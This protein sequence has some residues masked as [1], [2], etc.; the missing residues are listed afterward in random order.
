MKNIFLSKWQPKNFKHDC[1]NFGTVGP[2]HILQVIGCLNVS[3]K[4]W[5]IW[6]RCPWNFL[7]SVYTITWNW[8]KWQ[9]PNI[10]M[11]EWWKWLLACCIKKYF[12]VMLCCIWSQHGQVISCPVKCGMKLL[13]HSQTST[14]TFEVWKWICNIFP[15]SYW[16]QLLIH[17][18]IKVN[19]MLV[20]GPQF[21]DISQGYVHW[22][23]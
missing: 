13:S 15:A 22:A 3:L 19:P 17:T 7:L 5:V 2:K 20:K 6:K 23:C 21:C 12:D 11:I 8:F 18:G 10:Y 14:F 1:E 4:L 9:P 16:I